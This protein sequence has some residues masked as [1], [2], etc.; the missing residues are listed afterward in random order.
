MTTLDIFLLTGL[1]FKIWLKMIQ[2]LNHLSKPSTTRVQKL[3]GKK[4]KNSRT[5]VFQVASIVD[6]APSEACQVKKQYLK[7]LNKSVFIK[8][9]PINNQKQQ[10]TTK[11]I[12]YQNSK[13][14]VGMIKKI[15]IFQNH[16]I[17]HA[18]IK[19]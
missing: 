13:Q 8:L 10:L 19:Y 5:I 7:C 1:M 16:G 11:L 18:L 2:H 3:Q 14:I 12:I 6:S 9:Y 17:Q 15:L 4:Q